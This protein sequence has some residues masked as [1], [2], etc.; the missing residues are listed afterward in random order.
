MRLV[1]G[2][3]I[4]AFALFAFGLFMFQKNKDRFVLYL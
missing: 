3:W 2:G 4:W 1:I